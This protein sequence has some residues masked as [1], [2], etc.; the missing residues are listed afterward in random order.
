[1]WFPVTLHQGGGWD[2]WKH[3]W[4]LKEPQLQVITYK[5]DYQT[6]VP[7]G[8]CQK[9]TAE[10]KLWPWR[11]LPGTPWDPCNSISWKS[12][13]D[14]RWLL[15]NNIWFEQFHTF[16][17]MGGDWQETAK[18][19]GHTP[20]WWLLWPIWRGFGPKY[21][22]PCFVWYKPRKDSWCGAYRWRL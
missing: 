9:S 16:G 10:K 19:L 12:S 2:V 17:Q 14:T 7:G 8:G 11:W 6:D 22:G 5:G 4:T 1:M 21:E 18:V 13:A 15:A 20:G 3:S